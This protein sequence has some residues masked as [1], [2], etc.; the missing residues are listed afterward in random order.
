MMRTDLMKEVND[1]LATEWKY[2]TLDEVISGG[3]ID[4]D[5]NDIQFTDEEEIKIEEMFLDYEYQ[6]MMADAE[7]EAEYEAMCK[8]AEIIRAYQEREYRRMV[9]VA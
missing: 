2:I 3:W 4:E 7:A 1:W 8:E 5:G 6:K 9:A